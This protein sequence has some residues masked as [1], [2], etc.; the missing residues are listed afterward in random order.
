MLFVFMAYSLSAQTTIKG[1]VKDTNGEEVIGATILEKGT[2]NGTTTDLSGS[3]SLKVSGKS[4]LVISYV[5]MKT[6]EV[7]V[8]GKSSVSVVLREENTS[9]ND[10][11]V[12]GYGTMKK[13]D[14]TGA[15]SQVK[16]EE[17]RQAP[18]LNAME[19][20]QG[21]IAGLD[22]TR[23]SGQA[24]SSPKVL[25]RG[26]RSLTADCS[27]LYVIDGV[28]GGSI[29][30]LNPNDIESV[31][32][33]K[34][35]SSTAIYG[36]AGA[37][38]V[39]I[40]T[41]RQGIKGKTQVDFNA[42]AGINAWPSYPSTLSGDAWINFL[43]E[44]Y[45][46]STG[47]EPESVNDV[48]QKAGL[49]AG[50]LQAV[51]VR[52]DEDGNVTYNPALAKWIDWKDQILHTGVQQNYNVSIRGGGDKMQSYMS[53]GYQN[54]KGL[55]KNDKCDVLTF[56]AGSNYQ[57]NKILSVGFQSTLTY[58][59][60]DSRSSRLSKSLNQ[61]P[62]GDIYDENG[63]LNLRP[64]SDMSSYVNLLCDD[65]EKAYKNNNKY[66]AIKIAP[67]IEIKPFKG[68]TFKSLFNASIGNSRTGVWD[69]LNTYTKLSGSGV[70]NIR[71]A[72]YNTSNSWSY[73]WQNVLSYNFNIQKKHDIT[74]TG[75]TEYSKSKSESSAAA[76][77]QFD[78]DDFEFYNLSAGLN[79]SVSSSYTEKSSMSYAARINYSFLSRYLL[80]ASVRFDGASQLYKK[81]NT[82][83]AFSVGWRVSDEP[84]MVSLN[85]WL[86]NL[87][88]RVGYGVTGNS[89]ISAYVMNT[90]VVSSDNNLNLGAG[91]V[92]T[93]ILGEYIGNQNLTWEKSYNWN[94][95]LD[96]SVLGGRIDGSIEYYVTTTKGGLYS[97]DLPSVY[98]S[99][100]G[101]SAY[102]M[103]SNIAKIQN[104]GVEVSINSRNIV[105]KDFT[106]T[107]TLTFDTNKEQV[108]EID[109]G[110]STA[111]ENLKSK[112]LFMGEPVNTF[113][114]YKKEGIWQLGQEDM[115]A[116]FG[117]KP[118]DVKLAVTDIV[119]VENYTDPTT[120]TTYPYA[121]YKKN[122]DVDGVHTYY[123]SDN[124]YGPKED[125]KQLLGH[126][127]PDFSIGLQNQFTYK[128]FDL[129]IQMNMRWGQMINGELLGWWSNTNIPEV[130]D[131]WTETNATNNYPRP[132]L[133]AEISNADKASL[134][135]VDG[136]F[137]KVKNISLGYT[138]P[139]KWIAKAGLSKLRLY[140]TVQNPIIIKKE[141]KLLKGMD[142]ESNCSDAYPL[143]RTLVFGLNVSF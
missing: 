133:G 58:R 122:E 70:A 8:A 2:K 112:G 30:N 79:P 65:E 33:L 15:I 69:G 137:I 126:K 118:G 130:Y 66:T 139:N 78:F 64:I 11:V 51:G 48:F 71:N 14:L 99:Y 60:K 84:F 87:K 46:S 1:T 93:Y 95:G 18:V 9:L 22:I 57:I 36:A 23:E 40:V 109:L 88:L 113:Y 34:D 56:R 5:G 24:G 41:T 72:S 52:T 44:G 13:R 110:N 106:W 107:S 85:N 127:N 96:F 143:F 63:N 83:P 62:L 54:E 92:Q 12:I 37:N 20:L 129:T 42:Y 19:G 35:A 86:D 55:Y 38:G 138:F 31:E 68:L 39:I 16:Q 29:D 80:A 115:A 140:G 121:F 10:V 101:S 89:N 82:F 131:Y 17:I 25:L 76:N 91:Q 116:C 105:K 45:R 90:S 128:G 3:F 74:L 6:Q 81:W 135:Y 53:A 103:V 117:K 26:N 125:D 77:E 108:K 4:P 124:T 32:V 47:M 141:S 21:K 120:G 97:R 50:A 132:C 27:P 98:G 104:R 114:N 142:P 134:L 49:S 102:K 73:M 61:L 7:S 67:F 94:I 123:T 59:N 43:T 100:T 119:W 28:S 111:V 75:I 136:S